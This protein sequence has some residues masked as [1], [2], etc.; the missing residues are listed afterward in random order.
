[1]GRPDDGAHF[2]I[3]V[4]GKLRSIVPIRRLLPMRQNI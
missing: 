4:D 3:S 1:M 2:E